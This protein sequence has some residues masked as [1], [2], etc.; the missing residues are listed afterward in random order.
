[1]RNLEKL[2]LPYAAKPEDTRGGHDTNFVL[3]MFSKSKF[4]EERRKKH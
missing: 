4:Q 1:M 3:L 2:V